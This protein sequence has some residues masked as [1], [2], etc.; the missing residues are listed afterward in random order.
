MSAIPYVGG[1]TGLG[2]N[3]YNCFNSGNITAQN[4][5]SGFLL[6][7]GKT[8][9][10]AFATGGIAGNS[11]T[12]YNSYN[13]GDITVTGKSY[14]SMDDCVS[15]MPV[16]GG[17]AGYNTTVYNCYN[18][19]TIAS[20]N[21]TNNFSLSGGI[22]GLGT[23]AQVNHSY[24]R[25]Y[26]TINSTLYHNAIGIHN[27]G[28]SIQTK[29]GYSVRKKATQNGTNC[30]VFT[31]AT[32]MTYCYISANNQGLDVI[33][34]AVT[35]TADDP[36]TAILTLLNAGQAYYV[37][38]VSGLLPWKAGAGSPAHPVFDE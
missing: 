12:I 14:A 32:L 1:I 38:S 33:I 3:G 31:A 9:S 28:T 2:I 4:N 18:S 23:T 37:S 27:D 25:S 20:K 10:I 13:N 24:F 35:Y 30:S 15:S 34:D 7:S 17:I 36:G 19:G 6:Y 21:G 26:D 11:T 29:S 16:A 22:E 8:P 5:G